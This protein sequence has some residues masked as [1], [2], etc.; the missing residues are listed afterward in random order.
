MVTVEFG[1]AT[2]FLASRMNPAI[3]V[4]RPEPKSSRSPSKMIRF[5]LIQICIVSRFV[6]PVFNGGDVGDVED[7]DDRDDMTPA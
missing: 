7:G 5:V 4:P 6:P 1:L 2:T 3:N